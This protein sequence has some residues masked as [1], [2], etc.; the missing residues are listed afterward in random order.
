MAEPGS[1]SPET[2]PVAQAVEAVKALRAH[3]LL[4]ARQEGLSGLELDSASQQALARWKG[5]SAPGNRP[6][7]PR[8][9]PKALPQAP[10]A[11]VAASNPIET[12]EQIRADLGD[13]RRC[14]LCNGRANLV[15]GEGN[16]KAQIL[17]AGE[18][19]GREEDEQGRPFVGEAGRL[20]TKIIAAMGRS[21]EEVYIANVVKCRPPGNRDPK[22]D[23]ISACIPF[24]KRQIQSIRPIVIV[25]LGRVSAHTL[26]GVSTPITKLRG[27]LGF[28]GEF[29]V[30]P[31]FHP[32]YLLRQGG[33]AQKEAKRAVW[34]D[35]QE[36][37]RMLR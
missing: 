10:P 20:L 29:P 35:M 6:P 26:L 12:L 5:V 4:A 34:N 23:E 28:F 18:G 17:F 36:V 22:P 25:A 9:L 3:L 15:F 2:N 14:P 32:S 27:E 8:A 33:E 30:M 1:K 37:M 7:G 16:P 19:P 21:R 24:L 31:T 13:C 11:P